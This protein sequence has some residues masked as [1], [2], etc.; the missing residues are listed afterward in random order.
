KI[1]NKVISLWPWALLC[2]GLMIVGALAYLYFAAPSYH[3]NA[4]VLIKDSDQPG[5]AGGANSSLSMLQSLGLISGSS[6]VNNEQQILQSYT[7][8]NEVVHE[9]QLNVSYYVKDGLR[10]KELYG[11]GCPFSAV[12]S[13]FEEDSLK[14]NGAMSYAITFKKDKTGIRIDDE[15]TGKSW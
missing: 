14:V 7:L 2:S 5:G 8:M 13:R 15:I 3:V 6:N 12:F 4:A 11:T 9:M 10:T 1:V